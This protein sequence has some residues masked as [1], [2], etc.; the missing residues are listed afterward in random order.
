M[1]I[2]SESHSDGYKLA[3]IDAL[4]G[5]AILLVIIVH[6]AGL[7]HELPWRIKK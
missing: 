1:S 6:T 7:M 3:A 4:R 5:W 2:N